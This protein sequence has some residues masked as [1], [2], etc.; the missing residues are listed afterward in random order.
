M[1]QDLRTIAVDL[2]PRERFVEDV[3]MEER[4][5]RT[6]GRAQIE[7]PRLHG[8]NLMEPLDIAA[9]YLQHPEVDA[10]LEWIG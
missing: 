9:R 8:E 10:A 2:E 1:L 4:A 7:Q 6:D 5:L 3:A